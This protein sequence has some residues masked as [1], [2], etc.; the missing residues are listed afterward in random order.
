MQRPTDLAKWIQDLAAAKHP[1]VIR[2]R[3]YLHQHPEL[4]FEEHATARYLQR[5]FDEHGIPNQSIATTG[6]LVQIEGT[7]GAGPTFALRAD[8]DAL[9]IQ[10]RSNQPYRS[11]VA[12]VMH[13][14]GH[15]VH[16]SSLIGTALILWELRD[17]FRG[18][19]RLLFQPGEEQAPGG[20]SILIREGALENPKPIGIVGQHVHPPLE[21]GKVGMRPGIYMASADEIYLDVIGK[22]GHGA[23]PH[24][25]IDPITITAQV[26]TAAQQI[27]S[28]KGDPTVPSV[29]TFGFIQSDGGATN[30]IP[31]RVRLK[32]TFR[33]MNEE[34][35]R[36]ALDLIEQV[37]RHTAKALGGEV[38][39]LIK[40]GYPYLRNDPALTGRVFD[41]AQQYL[42]ADRVVELP[43]RMTAEDFAYYS[44]HLPACFYRLGVRNDAKGINSNIHTDTFDVDED[45]LLYGSGLMSWIALQELA[46][47]TT[48]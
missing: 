12:G 44:H 27:V 34:W 24:K 29:L 26:I 1:T 33:T 13:A 43:I 38:E 25:A 7:A 10:E 21:V 47:A 45:C 17:Q 22:G 3:R 11:S 4:S 18:T 32:G 39:L 16:T 14:C 8:L 41:H 6:L 23:L 31:N 37:V 5:L 48:S 2:H 40:K 42:G 20:A 36:A 9:P 30:V 19:V 28:R 46:A 15:D 35:R